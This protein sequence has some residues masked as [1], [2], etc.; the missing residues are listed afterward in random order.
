MIENLEPVGG[1][2]EKLWLGRNKI[3]RLQGLA[4]LASLKILSI[5]SNRITKIEGLEALVNLEELYLSHNGISKIEGLENNVSVLVLS[6]D[7][8]LF[9]QVKLTTLD[10]ASNRIEKLE[11]IAHLVN[12]EEF[13]CNNNKVSDYR[14]LDEL[15]HAKSLATVYFEHN[16]IAKDVN[17]R[18]KV[19]LALPSL[20]QIDATYVRN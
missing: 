2:L 5:Q 11:N 7:K 1:S 10:V 16:P 14:D 18:R 12:L 13:W 4:G 20:Q 6:L 9:E 19:K 17:Y 15:Q 8:H 3:D